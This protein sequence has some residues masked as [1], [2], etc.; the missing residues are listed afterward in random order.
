MS[1]LGRLLGFSGYFGRQ[2][3]R[4]S[5]RPCHIEGRGTDTFPEHR[6]C[7]FSRDFRP[8]RHF[9]GADDIPRR[10]PVLE[11]YPK[12]SQTPKVK[13]RQHA[14]VDDSAFRFWSGQDNH[15]ALP[16]V[17][18]HA[19][20]EEKVDNVVRPLVFGL[21]WRKWKRRTWHKRTLQIS[22]QNRRQPTDVSVEEV[23][24]PNAQ[25]LA[26]CQHH[27][28]IPARPRSQPTQFD[29]HAWPC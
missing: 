16:A 4:P 22:R 29:L 25:T 24:N 15:K 8:R 26:A 13:K 27:F 17:L 14:S 23:E 7:L 11:V 20:R 12:V 28:G 21:A 10:L 18:Q 6:L 3:N 19:R 1:I 2:Q 5:R 9:G